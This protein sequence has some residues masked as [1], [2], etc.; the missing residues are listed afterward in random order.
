MDL[1]IECIP[2]ENVVPEVV[3]RVYALHVNNISFED[4]FNKRYIHYQC[5]I[6]QHIENYSRYYRVVL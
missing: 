1:I 2:L 5:N 3:F 6:I 4:I